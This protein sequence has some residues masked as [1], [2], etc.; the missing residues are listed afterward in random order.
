MT[1]AT[2]QRCDWCHEWATRISYHERA[3]TGPV[4]AYWCERHYNAAAAANA[5]ANAGTQV[6]TD[7]Q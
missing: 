2:R 7:P 4:A 6:S 1:D 5:T 3:N